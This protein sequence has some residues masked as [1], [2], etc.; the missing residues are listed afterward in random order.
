M[1]NLTMFSTEKDLMKLTGLTHD[2]LW[3][4]DFDTDDWDVGFV[5]DVPLMTETWLQSDDDDDY[6]DED[7][8]E[9]PADDDD[10]DYDDYDSE[11]PVDDAW[12][13]VHRMAEYCVGYEHVEFKGRHY[14]MVHHA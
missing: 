3:E 11:V 8:C 7:E 12:W 9:S 1:I 13:L 10:Y 5:S 6:Y 2:E 14:Y 4:N